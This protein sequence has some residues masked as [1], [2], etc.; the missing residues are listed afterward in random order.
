MLNRLEEVWAKTI[1]QTPV[2]L[3]AR[4][5]PKNPANGVF[6]VQYIETILII[7]DN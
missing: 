2:A 7:N 3:S 1:P 4:K 5:A 6:L